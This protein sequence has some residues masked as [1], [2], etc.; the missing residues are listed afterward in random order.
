[1]DWDKKDIAANSAVPSAAS[2]CQADNYTFEIKRDFED[3][4]FVCTVK[5]LPSLSAHGDTPNEALREGILLVGHVL[6]DLRESGE[7]IPHVQ[8]L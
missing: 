1:M 8:D 4:I 2:A 5:E 6:D 7:P 3:G